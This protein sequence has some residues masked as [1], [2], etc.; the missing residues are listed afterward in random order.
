MDK[1]LV[2]EL[3][4]SPK[5]VQPTETEPLTIN[6]S[7]QTEPLKEPKIEDVPVL[8]RKPIRK[9]DIWEH[10]TKVKVSDGGE[11]RATCNYCGKDY[12]S[13][14]KRVGTSSMW[15]H[16]KNQCKKYSHNDKKTESFK[17]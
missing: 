6:V 16:L 11:S 4:S 2:H 14:S 7:P 8:K 5:P 10:F 9:S 17:F 1:Y 3:N 13:D 15:G 12:A